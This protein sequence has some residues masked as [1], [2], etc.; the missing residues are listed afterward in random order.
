[1]E[2][3]YAVR[4]DHR[5][6]VRVE[7]KGLKLKPNPDSTTGKLLS[8]PTKKLIRYIDK[9]GGDLAIGFVVKPGAVRGTDLDGMAEV[10][11]RGMLGALITKLQEPDAIR[12]GAKR[13]HDVLPV[14]D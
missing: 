3:S 10:F 13:L 9:H 4:S 5:A 1:M 7:L 6:A 11:W 8:A 2:V 12:K 14:D